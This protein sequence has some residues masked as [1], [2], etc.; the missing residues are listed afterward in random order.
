MNSKNRRP[1][2]FGLFAAI[3]IVGLVM[4][5]G[6]RDVSSNASYG[7]GRFKAGTSA[8]QDHGAPNFDI[9][10]D[11]SG[12][13]R[14]ETRRRKR[15]AKQKERTE[16]TLKSSSVAQERLAAKLPGVR[17]VMG[18]SLKTPERVISTQGKRFLTKP[19]K[20]SRE[21]IVKDFLGANSEVYGLTAREVAQLRKTADY[22]NPAGNLSWLE[23]R[24]EING[25]P[26]FQGELRA[27]LTKNGEIVGTVSRLAP[28]LAITETSDSISAESKVNRISA[29]VAVSKAAESIGI[30][31]DPGDLVVKESS[32]DGNTVLFEPGP[33]ADFI[34]VELQYFPL[35]PGVVTEA[36]SMVLWQEGPAY[37]V[38]V[39]A[40]EGGDLL[41][42]KNITNDQTQSATYSVYNDDSPGPLSPSN[43]L[44]GSAIQGP[45]IPRTLLTLISEGPAFNNLGWIPDGA[46][47]TTGNNVDAGLDLV[48]PN[49]IDP[50]GRAIGSPFRVFD[51]PYN[52]PPGIPAPG[53]APTGVNYRNGI[54]TDLFFW[55][56]RYHDRLYE[57]GF[58]EAARNFQL[59]NFG[60][61]GLGNDFVRAEAQDGASTNNANFATPADGLLPRMQ[62]FI[63]TGPTPDRDGDLDHEIVIHELTHGT[64][65]RLHANA[66]GLASTTSVG[67]GEG[68]SDF[69]GRA[70]LSTADE[71][72]NGIYPAGGYATFQLGPIGTDNYYYGIRRFPYA[73]KTTL[74]ANGKPHNPLTFADTDPA[75]LNTT[76]GAFPESPINFSGN[77][78]TEVHNLGEIWA[79]ALLEVRARIINNLGYATGNQRTLQIVTDGM[80]LDPINPT[81]LQGR[82]SI[83]AADCAGFAGADELQIWDG[84]ASRGMGFSATVNAGSSVTEAFDLPNL[85]L[86]D[87][88]VSNDSC[89]NLGVADP[90]ETVTL[91]IPLTNPFCA[92][93]ANGTTLSVDGG[94]PVSYG[95]IA[96][97]NTVSRDISFTV[98]SETECGT[99]LSIE[100]TINSSLGPVTRTF[101]LQVGAPTAILPPVVHSSG[102][103]AVPILD[104]TTVDIPITVPNTGAVGDVN[105]S[106]R[107]NHT[108][109]GDLQLRL[110]APDGTIV[111]LA[112]N[113]GVG[114]DNFGTGANDCSGTP[115]RFDDSAATPISAGV[116]PFAGT[117]RPETPLATLHGKEMNGVWKLRVSDTANLDQGTI[118]CVTLEI[119]E[120]LY[121]CCGVPGTPL[122]EA[123]PPPVLV[124]ECGTNGAADPGEV[125]TMSFALKN[126][127]SGLTTNLNATLQ[128]SG[129]IIALSGPQSYGVLSPVGPAVSRDFTF[130]VDASVA[131][132]SN[133][134]ATFV[135]DDAGVSLGTVS[136]TIRVG[137]TV[138]NTTTLS[139]PTSIVIPAVGT[140]ATTGA[141]SNPYPSNIGAA[142][143][144]GSVT[145]V[146]VT[147][148]NFS[149]T[150]PSDVDVLLVGPGGQKFTVLSDVIGGN[151]AVNITWV[152]DDGAATLVPS[153]GTAV[154]GTFRP[155]NIGTGDL[156]P[157]PAPPAPYQF[158]AT[159][160]AATFASVF[161]GLNPNGVW[162]LYVVDDAGIDVGSFAGGWALTITTQTPV[163]EVIPAV[164]IENPSVD[165]T[166]LW[167]PNHQMQDVTVNYDV[168]CASCSLSVSSNE[169]I[170]GT[171]D[172]DTDPDWEI[173][174][175]HH[176]RLRAERAA[177]GTG[178]IYTITITCT[179]GVNTDLET[180]EVHVD[181]NITGPLSGTAV[182]IN[183]PLNFSGTFWDLAGRTHSASWLFDS[184]STGGT[185]VEPSG[186]RKG[187]VSGAY[188]FASPGVYRVKMTVTSNQGVTTWVDTQNDL[189]ALVVIYDPAAGYAIGGGW[190]ASPPGA[191]LAN[192]SLTGKVSFGFTSKY[193]KN[194]TNP[195]GET[196]FSFKLGEVDFNAVNFDYLVIS[197]AKAQFKG[198]GKLNGSGAYSFLLTVIDGDLPGGGGVDR[199]RMK[200]WNKATGAIVYDNQ[201]GASDADNPT[202]P[203]GS[204]SA[205]TIKK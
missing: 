197:G 48:A 137:A 28:A 76:D 15:G 155:T 18:E 85:T 97:G 183:T 145:N 69:Y 101:I 67:M 81:M 21:K 98:P 146:R 198:F 41:W 131:C 63:F 62:M 118:G 72:I 176:V 91:S 38:F 204:G 107:L 47:T 27:A 58:T 35:E 112:N 43:A 79:M 60:R 33:F 104:N 32:S 4:S 96:A 100:A 7:P 113:R 158:P 64:S 203:V 24:Q 108:F 136:F 30:T 25:I 133:V 83:L 150:F 39:D 57:L 192:P 44:P 80:K 169:P 74:G 73:L 195:K 17:L 56:N 182:K 200:I 163:C 87:V 135:L 34:K 105:V 111:N 11:K 122:I 37:Y 9:R 148:N 93:S 173:V 77:G 159:A 179:N 154:S 70:L 10:H 130:A 19:S 142:G 156:F 99:Q 26:V 31:V 165:K 52:P 143:L 170:N 202:A 188:S 172:G 119:S 180:L 185:V 175:A 139:N 59:N 114:G 61:G 126:N 103:I 23:L 181:H 86:G 177:T 75:Q 6:P 138:T 128:S 36:W 68:W 178:R 54:V 65:N 117:F 132:G 167:P 12:Q 161:N 125:V 89:D 13:E 109:D 29:A 92:T 20:Q 193:F 129:G 88:I 42:R 147:L 196:Q 50:A 123:A 140:G 120:Q 166:S 94:S 186:S 90:G 164:D 5:F 106:V 205:I 153:T 141:P 149:H 194:A 191:Y 127:G 49:G 121:F 95:D 190:L 1:W 102:N 71:D 174:D 168:G 152:L 115:T 66:S 55:S 184:L 2:L 171:G 53:D 3:S 22:T 201:L 187:T 124:E 144:T 8:R 40:Q 16:E 46:N 82:D 199:F 157:A 78:A 14:L 160:G 189:E 116:P 134:T 45:A 51:F 162:S 110:I 151:D 84:F